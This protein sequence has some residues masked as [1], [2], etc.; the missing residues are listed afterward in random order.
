ML[1][2]KLGFGCQ[3]Q[4]LLVHRLRTVVVCCGWQRCRF[5]G[6]AVGAGERAGRGRGARSSGA[7][8]DELRCVT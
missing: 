2:L 7:W 6:R 3:P 5:G 4:H 1:L 8:P